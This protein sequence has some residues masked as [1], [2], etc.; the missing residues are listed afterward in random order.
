MQ[1][2]IPMDSYGVRGH[3]TVFLQ[4]IAIQIIM[5]NGIQLGGDTI[6]IYKRLITNNY[7][8]GFQFLAKS[9]ALSISSNV[10]LFSNS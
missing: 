9:F 1:F 4:S 8:N 3:R 5:F 6:P 7:S 2:S 10:I